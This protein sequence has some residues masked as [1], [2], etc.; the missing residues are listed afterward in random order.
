MYLRM[1]FT[2]FFYHFHLMLPGVVVL[3]DAVN[4]LTLRIVFEMIY[5]VT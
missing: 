4:S 1:F 2:S 5:S 3:E